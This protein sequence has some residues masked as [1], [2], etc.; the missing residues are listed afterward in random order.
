MYGT[1]RVNKY[2]R[3]LL[4]IFAHSS[5]SFAFS[6]TGLVIPAHWSSHYSDPG[7]R[8]WGLALESIV[9]C[10]R[11]IDCAYPSCKKRFRPFLYLFREKRR[12]ICTENHTVEINAT[13]VV[14]W[15]GIRGF[16]IQ[17]PATGGNTRYQ[18]GFR[19]FD[20][21]AFRLSDLKKNTFQR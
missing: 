13:A 3:C 15:S 9:N 1:C 14:F 4:G 2:P 20:S 16:P 6:H 10:S 18:L 19:F 12:H 7:D 5:H 8:N 21:S 17:D 11:R